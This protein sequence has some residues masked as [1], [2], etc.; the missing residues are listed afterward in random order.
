MNYNAVVMKTSAKSSG[1]SEDRIV[2]DGAR[3][4]GPLSISFRM[5]ADHFDK[6]NSSR[7]IQPPA[8]SGQASNGWENVC[9]GANGGYDG[10]CSVHRASVSLNTLSALCDLNQI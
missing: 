7:W 8:I 1:C 4:L 5:L 10:T 6:G 3:G 9:L 2:L